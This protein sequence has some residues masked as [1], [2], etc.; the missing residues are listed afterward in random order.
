M[1]TYPVPWPIYDIPLYD[2]IKP[3]FTHCTVTCCNESNM[4][5]WWHIE[6]VVDIPLS[7]GES[8]LSPTPLIYGCKYDRH[9]CVHVW[10]D[11]W[12]W[13]VMQSA[14]YRKHTTCFPLMH[15]NASGANVGRKQNCK[16]WEPIKGVVTKV[17]EKYWNMLLWQKLSNLSNQLM[18]IHQFPWEV[19]LGR[20]NFDRYN[21]TRP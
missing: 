16:R 14:Q 7:A 12:Q 21:A 4:F 13:W 2:V 18:F 10:E 15:V 11:L 5:L 6:I 8:C 9:V 20:V 19:E 1:E 3:V 17:E